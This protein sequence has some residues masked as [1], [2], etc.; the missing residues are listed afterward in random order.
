M[1]PPDFAAPLLDALA[2]Q[3]A[4]VQ[5]QLWRAIDAGQLT[6]AVLEDGALR[7]SAAGEAF[8]VLRCVG[9]APVPADTGRT[10]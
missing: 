5:R 9:V 3:P 1:M 6:F 8:C 2:E 7:F 10:H 4:D